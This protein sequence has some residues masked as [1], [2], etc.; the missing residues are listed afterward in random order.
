MKLPAAARSIMPGLV[1]GR[2]VDWRMAPS[3]GLVST[4]WLTPTS[5]TKA[6]WVSG[7]KAAQQ[8]AAWSAIV[9]RERA[10]NCW[11]CAERESVV[12]PK[13]AS[14]AR[15]VWAVESVEGMITLPKSTAVPLGEERMSFAAGQPFASNGRTEMKPVVLVAGLPFTVVMSAEASA[16]KR[17]CETVLTGP[18]GG[19]DCARSK[20]V[21]MDCESGVRP[22]FEI[23]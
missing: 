2:V 10:V 17:A 7:E 23:R 15:R 4:R 14:V 18:T 12:A 19:V 9:V 20:V 1:L 22:A 8:V 11:V 3:W 6:V 21:S 16:L 5:V 13:E